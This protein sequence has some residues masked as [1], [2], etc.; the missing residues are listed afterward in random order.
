MKKAT[1][2]VL[3]VLWMVLAGALPAYANNPPAPDGVF[4]VLLIFPVVILGFKFAGAKLTDKEMK[5]RIPRIIFLVFCTFATFAGTGIGGLGILCL[6]IYGMQRGVQAMTRGQG[7]K[8]FALG[9]AVFLFAPLAGFNYLLSLSNYPSVGRAESGAVGGIRTIVTAETT[10]KSDAKLD[11]NKNGISEFGTLAQ[12]QQAGLLT[13]QYTTPSSSS[14]Y[15][16]AVVLAED[17][18]HK[19]KEFFVYATPTHYGESAGF[20][21]SIL[22]FLRPRPVGGIRTFCADETGIIRFSDLRG[23]RAVTREEAQKWSPLQ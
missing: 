23:S 22:N 5:W 12:L 6:T 14:S 16:Y 19:E 7:K 2:R 21:I 13:G 9:A 10:F 11:A 15:R 18:T 20:S 17:P 1:R 8:R 3:G 4:S